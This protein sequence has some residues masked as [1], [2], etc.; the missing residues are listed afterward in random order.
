MPQLQNNSNTTS[1]YPNRLSK[2][3]PSKFSSRSSRGNDRVSRRQLKW[4][5]FLLVT[6]GLMALIVFKQQDIT[7]WWRLRNY[8]APPPVAQL[9]TDT[10]MTPYARKVF[11][12][13]T[14]DLSDK[15]AFG[16]NCPGNGGEET[17][18]L[19]CYR[20]GQH[21]IF[22]LDVTDERL[23]GVEQVTAAHEM[24]HA[25]Y[26]RLSGEERRKVDAMLL[27]YYENELHDTRVRATVDSYKST[28]PNDLL[29]EMHSI[30]ATEIV[31]LPAGL[32]KHYQRF[33]TNRKQV[34]GFAARY[35]AEF[36]SRKEARERYDAQ[37]RGLKQQ[38]TEAEADLQRQQA[39]I[40]AREAALLQARGSGNTQ[41]YNAGVPAYNG[42]IDAYNNEVQV[43]RRLIEQY[44]A[45]VAE[46]N[47]IALEESQLANELSPSAETIKQ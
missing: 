8:T 45:L 21:G 23:Q 12:V 1:T 22:L 6:W 18:V 27:A 26:D 4:L 39:A 2:L 19:G 5:L 38:I 3:K 36:T 35:Q 47:A 29:N 34:V 40:D 15:A 42:L 17:I 13:N 10:T 14:P 16:K 37:L 24:L 25:A 32:E 30:F 28:E 11:F 9:A 41:A 7:D 33:F 46:R 20:S 31:E 44:N 43:V